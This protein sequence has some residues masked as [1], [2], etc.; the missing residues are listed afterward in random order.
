MKN[1]FCPACDKEFDLEFFPFGDDIEC[2]GCGKIWG[3][4]YE[5]DSNGNLYGPWITEEK[6]L[7]IFQTLRTVEEVDRAAN[8]C[9]EAADKGS[10][11]LGMTYEDGFLAAIEWLSDV[12]VSVDDILGGN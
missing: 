12:E 9:A 8:I 5:E 1:L 2:R 4:E 10:S 11:Y 3:T 6:T 7:P